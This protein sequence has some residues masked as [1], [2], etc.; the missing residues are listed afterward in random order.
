MK[1][2]DSR[3]YKLAPRNLTDAEAQKRLDLYS[4][5]GDERQFFSIQKIK[6]RYLEK[7]RTELDK[8]AKSDLFFAQGIR[9]GLPHASHESIKYVREENDQRF[10]DHIVKEAKSEYCKHQNLSKWFNK[11]N[12]V[13]KEKPKKLEKAKGYQKANSLMAKYN[14]ISKPKI[15]KGKDIER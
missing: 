11:G 9:A 15:T 10:R 2:N 8:R 6:K 1:G 14:A 5:R 3:S 12:R 4:E 7:N 13:V